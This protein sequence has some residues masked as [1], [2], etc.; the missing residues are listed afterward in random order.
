MS[1]KLLCSLIALLLIGFSVPFA[2]AGGEEEEEVTEEVAAGKISKYLPDR[3]GEIPVP[4][5][6]YRIGCLEKTLINDFWMDLKNGYEAAGKEYGVEVDVYA[7]PTEADILVQKQVLEDMMAKKYDLYC[8]SPITSTNLLVPLAEIS[9]QGIPIINI[10]EELAPEAQE[11]HNIKVECF[12]TTD[13]V[14]NGR[15]ATEYIAKLLGP[16][17]G[18]VMHIM[19]MPGSIGAELRKQGYLEVVEKYP[20]LTNIGVWPGNWDRKQS[21]DVAADIIQSHPNLRAIVGANDTTALGAYQ[22]VKNAGKTDQ[23]YVAGIDAI[24]DAITSIMNGELVSTVAFMQY[25]VGYLAIE[26]GIQ[27]LEG[28]FDPNNSVLAPIQEVW[29]RDNIKDKVEQYR[30]Q[31]TGL[32]NIR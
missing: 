17:G 7:A 10:F 29:H 6:R 21:M 18:E 1:K 13:F 5:K 22:A 20:Q 16:E 32:R 24:P 26:V 11:K 25:Q 31:Y 14:D 23:I 27:M 9:K 2:F 30:E 19:G 3:V 4:S 28:T 12:I 15:Q 8:V